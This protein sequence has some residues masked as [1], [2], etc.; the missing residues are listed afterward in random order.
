MIRTA[1][2]AWPTRRRVA[3]VVLLPLVAA[4][5]LY[6]G[7]PADI[8]VGTG[9]YVAVAVAAL[10]GAGVLASY[11]PVAGRGL[12]L[13][14]TPCATLAA[15]TLVGATMALRNYGADIAGPLVAAGVLLFGLTQRLSQPATCATPV[16]DA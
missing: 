12:D 16:R 10:L 11:L 6:V 13:G 14:C 8:P 15:L 3:V 1:L 4:W 9:W 7:R 5:F 2:D